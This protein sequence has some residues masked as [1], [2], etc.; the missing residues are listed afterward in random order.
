MRN[1]GP[2]SRELA[3][4]DPALAALM[5]A[6]PGRG[7]RFG[8][9]DD[10]GYGFGLSA[11]DPSMNIGFGAGVPGA[12]PPPHPAV[13]PAMHAPHPHAAHAAHHAAAWHHPANP[14]STAG[15]EMLLD[16]NKHSNCKVER[17]EFSFSPPANFVLGTATASFTATQ[18]P[19]ASVRP[20][21]VVFNSPSPQFVLVTT[22]QI[23]NVNVMLGTSTD[24]F[25]YNPNAQGIM[26]DLP[27]LDPQNRATV[28]GGYTGLVPPG[29][30]LGTSYQFI[31]TVQGPATLAGGYQQ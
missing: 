6:L 1:I 18:N 11:F 13:H 3:S 30:S 24:A 5:G 28:S 10:Y 12:P 2:S 4:R 9:G 19:S 31:T 26:L 27:R 22:L 17:Y 23:A 21:R 7:A 8:F 15:R 16:P 25:T 29:F 20:Q 14:H